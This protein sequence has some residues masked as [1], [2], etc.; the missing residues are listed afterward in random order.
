MAHSGVL[1]TLSDGGAPECRGAQEK[2][3]SFLP[4]RQA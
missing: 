2:L 3:I 1:Y 4:S